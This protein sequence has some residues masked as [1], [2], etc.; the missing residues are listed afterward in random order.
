MKLPVRWTPAGFTK[1]PIN[2]IET[3]DSLLIV[4]AVIFVAMSVIIDISAARGASL[5]P[6][7]H[8]EKYSGFAAALRNIGVKKTTLLVTQT[9]KT[10]DNLAVPANVRIKIAPGGK[11]AVAEGKKLVISGP[12]EAPIGKVFEGEGSIMFTPSAIKTVYPEWWGAGDGKES[13]RAIQCAVDSLTK[14]DV[15]LSKKTY[16]LDR[17]VPM[18]LI[19]SSD[20]VSAMIVP[21]SGVNIVGKGYG[22]VLKVADNHTSTGDYVVFAPTRAETTSDI[23]FSNFRIDGN[24][25]RNLVRGQIRRAMAIWLYTGR[26][27]RINHVWFENQPGT[28]VVKFG[29][30]SLS[31][32]VTDSVISNC[33]FSNV[34]GAIP[35]NRGQ[36]D[37]S[38]LYISGEKVTVKNNRLTNPGPY[39]ENG[40]PIAVVAGIEMHGDN[41]VVSGNHVENYG[42]GGYIVGDGIVTAKN[43]QW[44]GNTFLNM[45]KMGI[46]IWS[47]SEVGNIVFEGNSITLNGELD[48]CV[49]G[50]YQPLN[51]P[52]TTRGIDGIIVRNNSI[53]STAT[54]QGTVW[55]GIMFNA[56]RNATIENN[57]I[58]RIS[59]A[60][61]LITGNRAK[62]LDSR[63]I[64]IKNNI[65]LDTS[66]NKFGAYPYAIEI[67]NEGRGR[68]DNISIAG[69]RIENKNPLAKNMG[70]IG[71][72]G[73]GPVTNV[74]I[75]AGN[76]FLNLKRK[77]RHMNFSGLEK[78]V[79]VEPP[80]H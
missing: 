2:R 52:D 66:F 61:I 65:V 10:D 27:I 20:T 36:S 47:I 25:S 17:R 63:N 16:L 35:G 79:T 37:H 77:D 28:N 22:S 39:N 50:I 58:E 70:G 44:T 34:G 75:N 12:F 9:L 68:F 53:D 31:Y 6:V 74:R 41:M 71:V 54:K 24:G 29:S 56:I 72:N 76:T 18:K 64:T 57:R 30:D 5:S 8:A 38:T 46:S 49:A 67:T 1:L 3:K 26:N 73:T 43:Q 33:V 45:T 21:R 11:I 32:L 59:G 62:S 13:S 40:P 78:H 55:C 69:N 19:G 4:S 48:Q 14:G 80:Q 15:V 51:P 7:A 60:A 23:T 42:N